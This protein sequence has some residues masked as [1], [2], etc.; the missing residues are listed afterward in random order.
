MITPA[1]LT[2]GGAECSPHPFPLCV[3]LTGITGRLLCISCAWQTLPMVVCSA[4]NSGAAPPLRLIRL[5][6]FHISGCWQACQILQLMWAKLSSFSAFFSQVSP[7]FPL[8]RSGFP[9]DSFPSRIL[10][11][12]EDPESPNH[13]AGSVAARITWM[14]CVWLDLTHHCYRV[15]ACLANP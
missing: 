4:A 14:L 2:F 8:L 9:M 7:W 6:L 1:Q 5:S 10:A 11:S 3:L 12:C 15:P 13:S